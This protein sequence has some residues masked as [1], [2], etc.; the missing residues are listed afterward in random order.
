MKLLAT[1]L[2]ITIV[3][4]KGHAKA[5]NPKLDE[6]KTIKGV[7]L[8]SGKKKDVRHYQGEI[9][10]TF[11]TSL[12]KMFSFVM[13]FK[14]RCNNDYKDRRKFLEKKHTCKHHNKNLIETVLI[15]NTKFKGAKEQMKR[16]FFNETLY[17]NRGSFNTELAQ[18]Y[19]YKMIMVK[20]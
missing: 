12:D 14:N 6:V 16:S 9:N 20:M 1:L 3:T 13:D 4:F 15:R 18:V 10:K 8:G 11:D 17:Y 5:Q 7:K 2:L 19:K